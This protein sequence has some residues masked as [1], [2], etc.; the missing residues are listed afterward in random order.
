[1]NIELDHFFILVEPGAKVA[2]RL[3]DLGMKE[4][5]SRVHKGQGTSN[6]RFAFANSMLEFL[7]VHDEDEANNGPAKGLNFPTRA[8]DPGA[9]PFG[10]VLYKK[11]NNNVGMPFPG[12]SYQP[13]Y[14][15]PPWAFHIGENANNVKE[16]LCI[17]VPF[18][19]PVERK[20]EPG[21]FRTIR[22]VK[23]HTPSFPLSDVINHTNTA[24]RIE[25][26]HGEQ[27][28]M[29]IT[30]EN[31]GSENSHDL[32]PDIPLIIHSLE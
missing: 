8:S 21:K 3:L 12:W 30:F 6:R 17:Y 9:S 13:E 18:L 22:S 29:E 11:D 25:I 27:H 10:V 28:L 20:R 15:D 23:I 14:F 26:A 2:D 24:D 5:F 7:W 16:P 4:E 19:G 31:F 1:M 32:R